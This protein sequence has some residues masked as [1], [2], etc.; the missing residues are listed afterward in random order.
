MWYKITNV[1]WKSKAA[2]KLVRSIGHHPRC[3][4]QHFLQSCPGLRI[5]FNFYAQQLSKFQSLSNQAFFCYLA[6]K[7]F[8]FQLEL[9]ATAIDKQIDSNPLKKVFGF[10]KSQSER[11]NEQVRIP[12]VFNSEALFNVGWSSQF[13]LGTI[14]SQ[15]DDSNILYSSSKCYWM[16][17]CFNDFNGF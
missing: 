14:Y 7:I 9:A 1:P 8:I 12:P 3:C 4:V 5:I 15:T 11:E 10:F 17:L 6:N 13:R 16:I 2:G